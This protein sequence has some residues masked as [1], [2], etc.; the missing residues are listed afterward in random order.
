[1]GRFGF[2]PQP[3]DLSAELPAGYIPADVHLGEHVEGVFCSLEVWQA[4]QYVEH[5]R[6]AAKALL[7]GETPVLFCTDYAEDGCSCFVGWSRSGKFLFE[8]W[9]LKPD[10]VVRTNLILRLRDESAEPNVGASHFHVEAA[11]VKTWVSGEA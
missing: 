9:L 8:E 6:C 11:D 5:W 2:S 7:A 1:M 4:D 10:A 3:P